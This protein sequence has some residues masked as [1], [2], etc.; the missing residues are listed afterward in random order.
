M[1]PLT[2]CQ[3]SRP[4]HHSIVLSALRWEPL[5]LQRIKAKPM[6]NVLNEIAPKSQSDL[7]THKNKIT[8]YELRGLFFTSLGFLCSYRGIYSIFPSMIFPTNIPLSEQRK[9]RYVNNKYV[10]FRHLGDM[11]LFTSSLRASVNKSHIPSLPQN[12]LYISSSLC[13][14]TPRTNSMKKSFTYD[15]ASVWKLLP[16]EIRE[17][18]SLRIK[19]PATPST[20]V[21]CQ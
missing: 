8:N 10:I 20:L 17:S 16:K 5:K 19:F 21:L 3:D 4:V 1:F 11:C 2:G 13:L 14:P 6:F 7:F 9:P 12:N 18:K 15:G